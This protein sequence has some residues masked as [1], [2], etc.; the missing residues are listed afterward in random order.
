MRLVELDR[1]GC[2]ECVHVSGHT[3]P[4]GDSLH[5]LPYDLVAALDP[6]NGRRSPVWDQ[7]VVGAG[8]EAVPIGRDE[9]CQVLVGEW[10]RGYLAALL[11]EADR[12]TD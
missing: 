10:L 2:P 6:S 1:E 9:D 5:R 11:E 12:S 7:V 8:P 3:G 4:P